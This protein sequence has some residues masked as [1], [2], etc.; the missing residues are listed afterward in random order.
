[1]NI[2]SQVFPQGLWSWANVNLKSLV[3]YHGG[4]MPRISASIRYAAD[5]RELRRIQ[6]SF[7][8]IYSMWFR[9]HFPQKLVVYARVVNTH[10]SHRP[11]G[12]MENDRSPQ[13]GWS[14]GRVWSHVSVLITRGELHQFHEVNG[15]QL[16]E[17]NT[18]FIAFVIW[19]QFIRE[20]Q[21]TDI[22]LRTWSTPW[23]HL[24]CGH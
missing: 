19:W 11:K 2:V 6:T 8:E 3:C 1:M 7:L 10:V 16:L 17:G 14:E 4:E 15:T 21:W 22:S 23:S 5:C 24:A 12:R 13:H 18:F 20:T 9:R